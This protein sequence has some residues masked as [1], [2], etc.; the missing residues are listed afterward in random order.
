MG[1]DRIEVSRRQAIR[2]KWMSLLVFYSKGDLTGCA[3]K[4]TNF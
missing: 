2:A 1:V 4:H 3:L